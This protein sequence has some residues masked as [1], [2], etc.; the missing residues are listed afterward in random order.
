MPGLP[1]MLAA[2]DLRRA[3]H[4]VDVYDAAPKAGGL[5]RSV[6]PLWKLPDSVLD[7]QIAMLEKGG[8]T[9]HLGQRIDKAGLEA[10]Q[11]AHDAVILALGAGRGALRASAANSCRGPCRLWISWPASGPG[12]AGNFPATS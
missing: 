6:L 8:V 10:L 5:P 9:F 2:Y 12:R 3:G 7:G 1:G 11:A 4:D